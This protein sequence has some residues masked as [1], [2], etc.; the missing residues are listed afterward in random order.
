MKTGLL[1]EGGGMRG[2]FTTGVLDSFMEAGI[3]FSYIVG[4]SSGAVNVMNYISGQKGRSKALMERPKNDQ[5][6]GWKEFF[7]S[8]KYINFGK[9]YGE[10]LYREDLKFD[11]DAYFKSETVG[12][13]VASNC[14]TGKPEYL[15]ETKD[16]KRLASMGEASCSLP[17][18]C[19]AMKI[20]NQFYMDG[21]MTDPLPLKRC[22]E[23]GCDKVV[24]IST[25]GDGMEPSNL[26]KYSLAMRI[27]YGK[28][29]V[30]FIEACKN[31]LDVYY[32]QWDYVYAE[33]NAGRVMLMHPQGSVAIG[34][35]D[36]DPEKLRLLYEEGYAYGKEKLE[37]VKAFL[38]Q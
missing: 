30:P 16:E 24:I 2:M 37:E 38:G 12:E 21:S 19:R 23:M 26:G 34:H 17:F 6:Y 27:L 14:H 3:E 11:F 9:L 28:K 32:A 7:R 20:D 1:L 18:V 13:Y 15:R 10:Y 35:L 33:E 22:Y 29:F 36:A 5:Y 25:K 31:R 4:V 8:G